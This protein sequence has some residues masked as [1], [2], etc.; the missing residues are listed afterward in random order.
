MAMAMEDGEEP[1]GEVMTL[2]PTTDTVN[3]RAIQSFST[4]LKTRVEQDVRG[5]VAMGMWRMG[6]GVCHMWCL[7]EQVS[8]KDGT[9][10][11]INRT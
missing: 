6:G 2:P 8:L 4:T 10:L 5:D 7:F 1:R 9:A 3:V 11:I